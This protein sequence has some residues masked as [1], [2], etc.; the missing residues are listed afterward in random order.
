MTPKNKKTPEH[1]S[2][3]TLLF[4][5]LTAISLTLILMTHQIEPSPLGEA[6]NYE[7]T[8]IEPLLYGLGISVFGVL[9][10]LTVYYALEWFSSYRRAYHR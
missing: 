5:S 3:L 8:S 2:R 4:L 10:A 6:R 7:Q 1:L 9:S